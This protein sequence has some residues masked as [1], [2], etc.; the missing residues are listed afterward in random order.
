MSMRT[1]RFYWLSCSVR[2]QDIILQPPNMLPIVGREAVRELGTEFVKH[3][4]SASSEV[5]RW[6]EDVEAGCSIC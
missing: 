3:L 1:F 4:V 5:E 6:E 2:T